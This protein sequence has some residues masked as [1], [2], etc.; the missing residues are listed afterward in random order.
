MLRRLQF[1]NRTNPEQMLPATGKVSSYCE[2]S[3]NVEIDQRDR[4]KNWNTL[5]TPIEQRASEQLKAKDVHSGAQSL[6]WLENELLSL[7]DASDYQIGSAQLDPAFKSLMTLGDNE[8]ITLIFPAQT[9]IKDENQT[10]APNSPANGTLIKGQIWFTN[11]RVMA[12]RSDVAAVLFFEIALSTLRLRSGEESHLKETVSA[13]LTAIHAG[14][15]NK[16]H[17]HYS[18]S[19][20]RIGEVSVS[21][22]GNTK[23]IG[24]V[25]FKT[26]DQPQLQCKVIFG[27]P[28]IP[29]R[30]WLANSFEH[31]P[32]PILFCKPYPIK[33]EILDVLLEKQHAK[34][35]TEDHIVP[36]SYVNAKLFIDVLRGKTS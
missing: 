17:L 29:E 28:V 6:Q 24:E 9:E 35:D 21:E 34:R 30:L 15:I 14:A 3:V 31:G 22:L 5:M 33:K 7:K 23:R 10:V 36:S 16:D 4:E 8:S 11:E 1:L 19:Y 20:G 27:R 13:W 18:I 2:E 32:T 26:S 25:T 12:V